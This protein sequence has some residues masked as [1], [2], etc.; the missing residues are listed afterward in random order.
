MTT[1]ANIEAF[2]DV[3]NRIMPPPDT[4]TPDG[5]LHRYDVPGDLTRSGNGWYVYYDDTPAAGAFGCW[6]RGISETW[7]TKEC[8]TF[9][10]EEKARYKTNME[11]ARRQR[12]E[13]EQAKRAECRTLAAGI[14][15][16]ATPAPGDHPYLDRKGVQA[17][18]LKIDTEGRLLVPLRD[19]GHTLHGLQRIHVDGSKRF[20]SGTAVT[21]C[22]HAIGKP[23]GKLYITE[24]YA[25]GATIYEATGGAVAVAFNAG[26][27]LAVAV[28]LRAEYPNLDLVLC[29]D[30]DHATEGNPGLT[31]ATEAAR[32]VSGKLAIPK[33][34]DPATKG[35]D[36]NDLATEEG[37]EIVKQIIEAAVVPEQPHQ[38]ERL[39]RP[40]P[41]TRSTSPAESFPIEALSSA[42]QN[43]ARRMIEVI[44]APDAIVGQS[45]LAAVTLAAQPHVD[46]MIDGRV[47]PVSEDFLTI[48]ES[49]ER[50]TACDREA[51]RVIREQQRQSH[52]KATTNKVALEAKQL[53]WDA[54]RRKITG[55]KN[56]S[57]E[58]I[59]I[60]LE[61]M[62]ERPEASP[63]MRYTEEPTYEGLVR[64]YAEG[65][66]SMG[67]FSDE[68]GRF[69]G[70]FAMNNDNAV[71]TITGLSKLWDGDHITRTRGGDGNILIYGVRLSVH[72]MIQPIL[73]DRVFSDPMLSG[74]GIL[75]RCFCCHPESTI[76]DRPYKDVDLSTDPAMTPY[77]DQLRQIADLKY[78]LGEPGMGLNPRRLVLSAPA[79]AMWRQFHDHIEAQ[80]RDGA[81]LRP[82]KGF[83]CKAAEHAARL[84]AVLAFFDNCDVSEIGTEHTEAG[85][86][87]VQF[88]LGEALRLFDSATTN[89]D[90]L[91]AEKVLTWANHADRGG[92]IPLVE[93]YQEGPRPIRNKA[94][95]QR[96]ITM[97]EDHQQVERVNGCQVNGTFRRDVWR[98]AS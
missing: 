86:E 11:A 85:I 23:N 36:F 94:T 88:Y 90:L 81:P 13:A 59:K 51:N 70:G 40:I 93:L 27:L 9:T 60:E 43:A 75:S 2:R 46:V 26:N 96:L 25:T 14:L 28:A 24:G 19:T 61:A 62:G 16:T 78:P 74:Q 32:A 67:L 68:G 92:L 87:L 55:T 5:V 98:V 45:L 17:H 73:A 63:V 22:Y 95:A 66:L 84:A 44:Q 29:A 31:K 82:V 91:L 79:K 12:D 47:S 1:T 20:M 30:D 53:A 33:F 97:L 21:G 48:A 58:E 71:K 6:K 35:T 72:L 41:L 38:A 56:L 39:L 49:G 57:Y 89:P 18:G 54:T 8:R 50:K 65:N 52:H 34:S 10:T 42:M 80:V 69:L 37:P 3:I 77:H 76:G 7:T 15:K 64:G 83:A 4:I